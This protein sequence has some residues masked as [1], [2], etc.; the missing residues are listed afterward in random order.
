MDD[1]FNSFIFCSQLSFKIAY[2]Y[3][4]LF[5]SSE[6]IEKKKGKC[7]IYSLG[8]FNLEEKET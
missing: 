8:A 5:D 4:R 7:K 2:F 1:E 6:N 3:V